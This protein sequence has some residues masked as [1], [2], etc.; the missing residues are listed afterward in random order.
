MSTIT[1]FDGGAFTR[2]ANSADASTDKG[3]AAEPRPG[4]RWPQPPSSSMVVALIALVIAM[5]GSAYAAVRATINGSELQNRSVA[6]IKLER[7]TVTGAEINKSE[8]GQVPSAV[9][10]S[11]AAN[12][13]ALGGVPAAG[14]VHGAGHRLFARLILA[15]AATSNHELLNVPGVVNVHAGCL[16]T[17]SPPT[18]EFSA[19]NTSGNTIDVVRTQVVHDNAVPIS[20]DGFTLA[21]LAQ[22]GGASNEDGS[23][24][25]RTGVG[26]GATAKLAI[27]TFW[28]TDDTGTCDVNAEAEYNG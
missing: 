12:A 24:V 11:L 7:Q 6:G 26:T 21:P 17:S 22:A 13:D 1:S 27:V 9:H 15:A 5:G 8:L 2:P 18:T 4:R 23:T 25:L 16:N 20:T 10:A 19:T 28:Y 3:P 14:L